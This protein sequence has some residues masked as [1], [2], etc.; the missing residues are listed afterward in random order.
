[1]DTKTR[2]NM[3]RLDRLPLAGENAD[4]DAEGLSLYNGSDCLFDAHLDCPEFVCGFRNG[5][6]ARGSLFEA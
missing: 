4:F 6:M 1:M 3:T 5:F 2:N